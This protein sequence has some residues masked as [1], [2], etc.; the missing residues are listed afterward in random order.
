MA[1]DEAE[2]SYQLAARA[3]EELA[4]KE[5]VRLIEYLA[6]R[7]INQPSEDDDPEPSYWWAESYS[8][9][10]WGTEVPGG[11]DD[12]DEENRSEFARGRQFGLRLAVEQETKGAT[13]S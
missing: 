1:D 11:M 3:T 4:P 12:L 8:A 6:T 10:Y 13:R 2:G 5:I 7:L 9:G